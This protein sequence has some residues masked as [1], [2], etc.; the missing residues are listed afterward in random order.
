MS[1]VIG[2]AKSLVD[3]QRVIELAQAEA[4]QQYLGKQGKL[5]TAYDA[6]MLRHHQQIAHEDVQDVRRLKAKHLGEQWRGAAEGAGEAVGDIIV[7]DDYHHGNVQP[8]PTPTPPTPSAPTWMK[9]ALAGTT[10]VAAALGGSYLGSLLNRPAPTQPA[11][12]APVN[13]TVEKTEGFK[14]RLGENK[15]P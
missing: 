5:A 9:A 6:V 3:A 12:V 2:S 7:C 10:L 4:V 1:S 11:A 15:A 14:L 13:T 8:T